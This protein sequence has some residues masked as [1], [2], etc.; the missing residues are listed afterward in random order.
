MRFSTAFQDMFDAYIRPVAAPAIC[1]M[2]LVFFGW[3]ALAGETGLLK[4]GEYRAQQEQLQARAAE[5]AVIRADLENKVALLGA[6]AEPDYAEELV[7]RRLGLVR[8]DEIIV[9]LED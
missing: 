7:R 5:T 9:R 6:R 3:H 1:V 8:D 2:A 4:L